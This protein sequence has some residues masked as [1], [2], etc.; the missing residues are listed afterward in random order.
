VF[1]T[2]GCSSGDFFKFRSAECHKSVICILKKKK[3]KHFSVWMFHG[4]R[5][6]L[7]RSPSCKT[8]ERVAA[9]IVYI[10]GVLNRVR[11][12]FLGYYLVIPCYPGTNVW[13][14]Q[15]HSLCINIV[16]KKICC[17]QRKNR[18]DDDSSTIST[19]NVNLSCNRRRMRRDAW[20]LEWYF[21]AFH[22]LS[23]WHK[24]TMLKSS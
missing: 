11:Y 12:F 5:S 4:A 16:F 9:W 15:Q 24:S 17:A 2:G 3:L 7:F 6:H 22:L 23:D 8:F 19:G 14:G 18:D 10:Y 1:P 21:C 20:K 13:T